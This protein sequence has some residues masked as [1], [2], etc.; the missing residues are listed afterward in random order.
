MEQLIADFQKVATLTIVNNTLYQLYYDGTGVMSV[1]YIAKGSYIGE[2]PGVPQYIWDISHTEYVLVDEDMVLDVSMNRQSILTYLREDSQSENV[3]NCQII[4]E[5][6]DQQK[7]TRV[8]V[9]ATENIVPGQEI[10]Y[11]MRFNKW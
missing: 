6:D 9:V 7:E 11:A 5:H 4:V 3:A 8:F 2:I 10:V 1:D